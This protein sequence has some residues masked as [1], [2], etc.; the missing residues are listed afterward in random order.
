M[1]RAF[2]IVL[3]YLFTQTAGK[4]QAIKVFYENKDRSFVFYASNDELYPVSIFIQFELTNLLFSEG[5]R[6]VFIL[7]PESE[8][9]KIG[10]LT[11]G[12]ENG[13]NRFK[14]KYIST[15]GDV[16]VKKYDTAFE[17]DLPFEKE[18][19]YKLSQGYNGSFSHKNENALDFLMPEGTPVLAA[20]EGTV[21]KLVQHNTESC[22]GEECKKYNNYVIVMHSDGTFAEYVHIKYNGAAVKPGDTVKKGDIIAFSGNV[23]LS[24]GPH[25]HFSCF[26]AEFG[27]WKTLETKF[28][29]DDGTVSSVLKEGNVY[30]RNY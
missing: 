8:K 22:T 6:N 5:V 17:Y 13:S 2:L 30:A 3:I 25:L 7:P 27:K 15:M 14:Y 26:L 1:N 9:F 21:V 11:P 24:S 12:E 4:A 29:A 28:R 19:K 10:E 18:K 20:R 16:T 23:G